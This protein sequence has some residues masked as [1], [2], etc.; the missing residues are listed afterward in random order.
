MIKLFLTDV[1]GTL[2]NGIYHMGEDGSLSKGFYSRDFHGM[3]MLNQTGV[4][5]GVLSY[6][7]DKVINEQ[8]ERAAKY[9]DVLTG[10][11]DKVETVLRKY[12]QPGF[13][14]WEEIAYI[15]DD[16][17]DIAILEKVGLPACPADA[18]PDVEVL[19]SEL[20]DGFISFY[21]GGNGAVRDFADYI[22]SMQGESQ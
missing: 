14:S 16:V 7:R 20:N 1:D 8:C 6:S 21:A 17:V 13:C 11:K 22:R 4:K 19:V 2:T 10:S 3:Y 9:A 18:H 15:G 5:V 12:V